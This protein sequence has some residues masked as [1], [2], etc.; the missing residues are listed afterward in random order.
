MVASNSQVCMQL[1]ELIKYGP[2]LLKWIK[3]REVAKELSISP[4]SSEPDAEPL[5][6]ASQVVLFAS[7][8]E[9]SFGYTGVFLRNCLNKPV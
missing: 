5:W 3:I 8:L 7:S 2:K 1:R 9:V 6:D 4:K